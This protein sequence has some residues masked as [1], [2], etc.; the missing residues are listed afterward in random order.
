MKEIVDIWDS[1]GQFIGTFEVISH[2]KEAQTLVF[3]IPFGVDL[4]DCKLRVRTIY[5]Q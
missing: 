1:Y 3:D 2:D 5:I 4:M